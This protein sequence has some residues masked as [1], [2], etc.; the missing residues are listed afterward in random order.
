MGAREGLRSDIRSDI[1]IGSAAGLSFNE[2][3]V[4][5]FPLMVVVWIAAALSFRYLFRDELVSTP[6]VVDK[7]G[8]VLPLEAPGIGV[9]VNEEFLMRHPVIEGP[10]Y[11]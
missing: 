5:S 2:F 9:E 3:L 8:S 10:S 6:Y 7:N 4:Y 11:V 1:I